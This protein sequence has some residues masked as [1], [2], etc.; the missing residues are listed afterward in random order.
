MAIYL[1]SRCIGAGRIQSF[2]ASSLV[3]TLPIVIENVNTM[4]TDLPMAAFFLS[5][6]YFLLVY[7]RSRTCEDL[8]WLLASIGVLCGIKTSG[9]GYAAVLASLVIG[10]EIAAH[11]GQKGRV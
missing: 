3:L 5:G 8:A 6:A 1:L 4:H 2:A 10:V 7:H 9:L 11:W